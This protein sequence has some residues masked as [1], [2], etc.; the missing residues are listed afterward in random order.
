MTRA[1]T[2]LAAT[3]SLPAT[4]VVAGTGLSRAAIVEAGIRGKLSNVDFIH[5]RQKVVQRNDAVSG[6]A[7]RSGS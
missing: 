6:E 5:P 3:G 1:V 4:L 2:A 7:L